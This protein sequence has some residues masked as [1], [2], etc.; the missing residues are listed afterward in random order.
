MYQ[1]MLLENE[2]LNL[3]QFFNFFS[4][5]CTIVNL[6]ILMMD[7]KILLF[8]DVGDIKVDVFHIKTNFRKVIEF[9]Y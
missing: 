9:A 2:T 5:L 4:L 6:K 3:G 7:F 8:G 1:I